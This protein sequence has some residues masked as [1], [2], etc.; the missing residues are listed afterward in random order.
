[1]TKWHSCD[2][3]DHTACWLSAQR[4]TGGR[5]HPAMVEKARQKQR[6]DLAKILESLVT[7]EFLPFAD[8]AKRCQKK[9]KKKSFH[10]VRYLTR[11]VVPLLPK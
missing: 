9:K 7:S 3:Q 6:G 5:V 2:V 4:I 8:T 11:K 10:P 1:M